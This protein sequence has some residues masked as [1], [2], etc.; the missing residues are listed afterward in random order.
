MLTWTSNTEQTV[1]W[2]V[3]NQRAHPTVKCTI[4]ETVGLSHTADER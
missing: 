2:A 4:K 3:V 1:A